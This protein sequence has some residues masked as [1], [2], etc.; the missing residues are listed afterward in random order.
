MVKQT[1]DH[2]NAR[3]FFYQ[4]GFWLPVLVLWQCRFQVN[5]DNIINYRHRTE[6]AHIRHKPYKFE[7]FSIVY[8]V[9]KSIFAQA[10]SGNVRK[11]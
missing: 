6:T 7:F 3:T 1:V 8:S 11:G 5:A 4:Y 9:K 2:C 10:K